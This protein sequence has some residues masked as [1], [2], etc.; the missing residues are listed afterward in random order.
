M[1]QISS[2]SGFLGGVAWAANDAIQ[3]AYPS[4]YP[5]NVQA[6]SLEIFLNDFA[7]IEQSGC[8]FDRQPV[9]TIPSDL[10]MLISTLAV[11][12]RYNLEDVAPP[13]VRLNLEKYGPIIG[14]SVSGKAVGFLTDAIQHELLGNKRGIY[15]SEFRRD[16]KDVTVTYTSD[17]RFKIIRGEKRSDLQ[18]Y[19]EV[20]PSP[21]EDLIVIPI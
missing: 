16:H 5:S 4:L 10:D 21:Q 19:N 18:K 9:Y 1:A 11:W 17:G 14:G 12:E 2:N 20:S 3:N 13:R 7:E 8:T 6:F 15:E